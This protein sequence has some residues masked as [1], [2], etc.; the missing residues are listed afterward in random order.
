M[1]ARRML[2]CSGGS[3]ARLCDPRARHEPVHIRTGCPHAVGSRH[4]VQEEAYVVVAGSGRAKLDD[5]VVEL[6]ARCIR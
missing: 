6:S 4:R 1:S 5:E 3:R 2:E